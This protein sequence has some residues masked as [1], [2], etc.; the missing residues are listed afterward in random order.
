MTDLRWAVMGTGRIAA[1]V[2]PRLRDARGCAFAGAASRDLARAEA[3]VSALGIPGVRPMTYEDLERASDIDAVYLTLPNHLHFEWCRRLME[4]GKHVL[5]EKP[6]VVRERE[7][8]ALAETSRRRRYHPT[9]RKV[10][11]RAPRP[12]SSGRPAAGS[13]RS[14][15]NATPRFWW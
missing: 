12:I 14:R 13:A 4:S 8:S 1:G 7:A 6:L 10:T 5:C 9:V 2:S 15:L 11:A 3:F